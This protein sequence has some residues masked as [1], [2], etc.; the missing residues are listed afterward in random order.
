MQKLY[1]KTT[2][3]CSFYLWTHMYYLF[4]VF[5]ESH[6]KRSSISY[7]FWPILRAKCAAL[8]WY[9]FV[10]FYLKITHFFFLVI[11]NK[12][13]DFNPNKSSLANLSFKGVALTWLSVCLD[14]LLPQ[15]YSNYHHYHYE[16]LLTHSVS[17]RKEKREGKK[18][19][20]PLRGA[21]QAHTRP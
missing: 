16:H 12:T 4:V 15:L 17:Q 20:S 18:K 5:T 6:V 7:I 2:F 3:S 1:C 13:N 11:F 19:K 21:Y 10:H 8:I 14:A 9:I